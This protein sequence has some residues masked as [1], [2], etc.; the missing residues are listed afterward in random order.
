MGSLWAC[1]NLTAVPKLPTH[2][3]HHAAPYACCCHF[4]N[5]CAQPPKAS[6]SWVGISQQLCNVGLK[7]DVVALLGAPLQSHSLLLLLLLRDIVLLLLLL[8]HQIAD[9]ALLL[10]LLLLLPCTL[11]AA[12]CGCCLPGRS[13]RCAGCSGRR[14]V[15]LPAALRAN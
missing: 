13:W 12:S 10:L 8:L 4:C 15:S 5:C 14:G 3:P 6:S 7:V 11:L 1:K 9:A 2:T